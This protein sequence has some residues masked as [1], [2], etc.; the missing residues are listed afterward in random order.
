MN[1]GVGATH[2]S[3]SSLAACLDSPSPWPPAEGDG[4]PSLR[5]RPALVLRS[6]NLNV[7][8]L[9]L[10]PDVEVDVEVEVEGVA[11]SLLSSSCELLG[12]GVNPASF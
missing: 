11:C 3:Q 10:A 1:L 8:A 6:P 2:D 4:P 12:L 7:P 5:S 9:A